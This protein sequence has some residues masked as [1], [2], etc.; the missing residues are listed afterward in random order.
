[1][2]LPLPDG[3]TVIIPPAEAVTASNRWVTCIVIRC[4]GPTYEGMI[5][6]EYSPMTDTGKLL[7][8]DA[9]GNDLSKQIKIDDLFAACAAKPE[10]AA[11][12]Q[13]ILGSIPV[14][15]AY[16]KEKKEAEEAAA[17]AAGGN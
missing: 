14:A 5:Q 12:M 10:I 6:L 9:E 3:E 16:I 17:K 11:T 2:P 1:M 7:S 4:P 13:A 15:E 8:R